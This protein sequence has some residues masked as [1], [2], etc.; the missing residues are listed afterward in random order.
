MS[1]VSTSKTERENHDQLLAACREIATADN[2]LD[3]IGERLHV[4]GLA[5]DTRYVKLAYLALMTRFFEKPVSLVFKGESSAGK[6]KQLETALS[7][8]PEAAYVTLTAS[9]EKAI[10]FMDDDLSHRFLVFQEIS[11]MPSGE[12]LKMIRSLLSERRIDYRTSMQDPN[13]G[14]RVGQRILKSGPTGLLATT[15][16]VKLFVEDETRFLSCEVDDSTE[17]IRE[18]LLATVANDN[19]SGERDPFLGA[20]HA[21]HDWI[22]AGEH[23]V[24]IPFGKE[25]AELINPASHRIKRDFVHLLSL[26]KASALLHQLDRDRDDE[27]G[28][29]IASLDD[30]ETVHPLV[31]DIVA[32]GSQASVDPQVRETVGA[33]KELTRQTQQ[34]ELDDILKMT[35]KDFM[36]SLG[37]QVKEVA[38]VLCLSDGSAS[39]RLQKAMDA[40]FIEN[41]EPSSGRPARYKLVR[42]LPID[43]GVIPTPEALAAHVERK[44]PSAA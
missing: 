1:N 23:E 36:R 28:A 33:V 4:C 43:E 30:Y 35:R 42:E 14:E 34:V 32:E 24:D 16:R 38:E 29:I 21:F 2:V 40:G 20:M 39:R 27:T 13:S 15:T 37:V 18:V 9:S 19:R 8:V 6:S 11:G 22:A 31:H 5:G 17:Q 12:G 3:A 44:R 7:L 26:I 25:L 10:L 41:P